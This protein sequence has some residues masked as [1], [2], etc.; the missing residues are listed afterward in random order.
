M[1]EDRKLTDSFNVLSFASVP[2]MQAYEIIQRVV[3]AIN[4]HKYDFI[5]VNLSNADMIGHTGDLNAA[6]KAIK[7]VD[8][9]V[10]KIVDASLQNNADCLITADHGNAEEM[11]G[12]DGEIITSHTTNP[13]PVILCSKKY[14][15][16]KL[17][18]TGKLA[19]IAPTILKLLNLPIPTYM[20]SPLF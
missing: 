18:P 2:H 20:D 12:K 9:C 17:Q 6:I 4:S 11:I 5:L 15:T 13:V 1:G 14:K 7:V 10:Q 19:N 16:V 8:E 3:D